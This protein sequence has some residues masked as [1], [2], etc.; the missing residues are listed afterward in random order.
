MPN[1]YDVLLINPAFGQKGVKHPQNIP[2][3]LLELGSYLLSK[4]IKV[5]IIDCAVRDDYSELVKEAS[6]EVILVGFG[7]MTTQINSALDLTRIIKEVNP[8]VKFVW[9]GVHPTLFPEQTIK[10]E[11][12]DFV[13]RGEGEDPLYNLVRCFKEEKPSDDIK[14]L[15]FK[16]GNKIIKNPLPPL[17]D[18]NQLPSP[19]WNLIDKEMLDKYRS[20]ANA[21]F[22]LQISTS[23]GCPHRCTF[24]INVCTT[25]RWRGKS[26]EKVINE[27]SY[28]YNE[29][30]IKNIKFRDECF[31]VD[32]K[33]VKAILNGFIENKFDLQWQGNC[34]ADYFTKG[35]VD[36]EV[37]ELAKKTNCD[38]FGFGAESGSQRVLDMIKKDIKL[39]DV[40][41][42]AQT[43]KKYNLRSSYSFMTGMPYETKDEMIETIR[44][45]RKLK[46]INPAKIIIIGPQAY[47]PY[48]GGEMYLDALKLG[49]KEPE[50]LEE[51]PNLFSKM[52]L[53][54]TSRLFPWVR[55]STYVD[56]IWVYSRFALNSWGRISNIYFSSSSI[57]APKWAIYF[58]WLWCKLRWKLGFYDKLFETRILVWYYQ[59][60][61]NKTIKWI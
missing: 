15:V 34:R 52:D 8:S 47:R 36:E 19:E 25:N 13:I 4:G 35:V 20:N 59:Q 24:C 22:F 33:R 2:I 9:G 61:K 27:I 31:F 6:K 45:I 51:W 42:V 3:N 48:P 39:G 21:S 7:V 55:D 5:K 26:P 18:V 56:Y 29:L 53:S 17:M 40:L 54:T 11:Y 41:F 43:L 14:G 60:I 1:D 38:E 10:H 57:R 16:D 32:K 49:W 12:V 28:I 44:F 58:F 23:R 30:K 46:R 50:S 37:L